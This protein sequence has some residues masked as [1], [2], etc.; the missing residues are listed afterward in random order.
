[1]NII[2]CDYGIKGNNLDVALNSSKLYVKTNDYCLSEINKISVVD[3]KAVFKSNLVSLN[4]KYIVSRLGNVVY[5]SDDRINYFKE[6]EYHYYPIVKVSHQDNIEELLFNENSLLLNMDES[7]IENDSELDDEEDNGNNSDG[8]NSSNDDLND[9]QNN[10][11][12]DSNIDNNINNDSIINDKLDVLTKNE[13]T[14]NEYT[15]SEFDRI[16]IVN[17]NTF[18]NL[19][20]FIVTGLLSLF[21]IISILFFRRENE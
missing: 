9:N 2:N 19:N 1:M 14:D 20:S 4:D 15:D 8:D 18:D 12:D 21:I 5:V 3:G 10:N 16:E 17:P 11:K 13:Y 6:N 7:F